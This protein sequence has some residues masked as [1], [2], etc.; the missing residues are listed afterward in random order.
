M[1]LTIKAIHGPIDATNEP[2]NVK[3][4]TTHATNYEWTP[5]ERDYYKE[6]LSKETTRGTLLPGT[7]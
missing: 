3:Q 2:R 1:L 5:H 7:Y 6:I 4:K